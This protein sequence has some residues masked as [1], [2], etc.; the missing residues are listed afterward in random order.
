MPNPMQPGDLGLDT[1]FGKLPITP[2][3]DL[4][5]HGVQVRPYPYQPLGEGEIL[6]CSIFVGNLSCEVNNIVLVSLFQ[7]HFTSCELVVFCFLP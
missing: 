4:G 2:I 6:E 1:S 3:I 7:S 5:Q